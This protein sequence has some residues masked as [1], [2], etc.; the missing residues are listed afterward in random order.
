MN[1]GYIKPIP[2][3]LEFLL[4]SLNKYLTR[5][6]NYLYFW[7]LSSPNVWCMSIRPLS[8][9]THVNMIISHYNVLS[10]ERNVLMLQ[11]I[12]P[13]NWYNSHLQ[14]VWVPE[15]KVNTWYSSRGPEFVFQHPAQMTHKHCNFSS[16]H[17]TL[18]SD[19]YRLQCTCGTRPGIWLLHCPS[20][21]IIIF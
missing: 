19:V 6:Q 8:R 10:S 17:P 9:I 5:L 16:M 2:C 21:I 12:F 18:S 20:E 3:C 11:C 7:L 13:I 15:S 4:G 14:E 1:L